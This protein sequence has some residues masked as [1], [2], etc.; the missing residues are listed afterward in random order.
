MLL[1][2]YGIE[3]YGTTSKGISGRIKVRD[4]DFIVS[5]II[6]QNARSVFCSNGYPLFTVQRHGF[7][8]L[9]TN[10]ILQKALGAKFNILGLKDKR[11]LVRQF[12][13][14]RVKK[15]TIQIWRS[16]RIVA[17]H[18]ADTSRPLTRQDLFGNAFDV[19]IDSAKGNDS[20]MEELGVSLHGNKIPNFFGE[21]RF[22]GMNHKIGMAIVKRDFRLASELIGYSCSG[23]DDCIK[24]LRKVQIQIRRLF[25]NSLQSYL[26][27]KCLSLI[28]KDRGLVMDTK[29]FYIAKHP[30]IPYVDYKIR[31]YDQVPKSLD[32]VP[33]CPLPGYAFRAREDI[34][35]KTM[36]TVLEDEGLRASD[37][38]LK[39][40]QELS[41]EG[42]F[43]GA[44][45][46]GWF[47]G[48]Q[49]DSG[50]SMRLKFILFKGGYGTMLLREV[51]KDNF[52]TQASAD[53][54]I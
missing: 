52:T 36:N 54:G 19:K 23:I 11:A 42:G 5:E 27:N 39:E 26:F 6:S 49:Q 15:Q 34:Y 8:T 17:Y 32:P 4:D 14:C 31:K 41:V 53:P 25:I 44:S 37:F 46:I 2:D 13:S 9:E 29:A 3:G 24:S 18:K 33:L 21:Q 16:E 51:L 22:S 35:S 50:S 7:T 43:R 40:M 47:K 12:F 45:M 30:S 10:R 20:I 28:L 1:K 38:Y 48:W